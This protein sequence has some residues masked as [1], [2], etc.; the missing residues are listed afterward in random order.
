[1]LFRSFVELRFDHHKI[2][3]QIKDDGKGFVVGT[4]YEGNGLKNMKARAG[5]IKA[6][7]TIESIPEQGTTVQVETKFT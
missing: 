5:E 2:K 3:V 4:S 1:M 7:F 6:V